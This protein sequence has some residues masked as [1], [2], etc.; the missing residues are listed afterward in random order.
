MHIRHKRS[1]R[2]ALLLRFIQTL[3]MCKI[4]FTEPQRHHGFRLT[5]F[6]SPVE[7]STR[8]ER[9]GCK[10]SAQSAQFAHACTL[11]CC[12]VRHDSYFRWAFAVY[13]VWAEMLFCN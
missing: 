13:I 11:L 1:G 10:H 6:F 3:S 9:L 5:V 8:R 12:A 7:L 4:P 2:L